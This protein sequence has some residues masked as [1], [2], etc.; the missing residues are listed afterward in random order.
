MS[1]KVT[2]RHSRTREIR[3]VYAVPSSRGLLFIDF[4][5]THL[6]PDEWAL[7]FRPSVFEITLAVGSIV[8][9]LSILIYQALP[10]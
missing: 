7:Y 5:G 4:T 2:V 9:P 3:E 8:L 6:P 10:H 1:Q